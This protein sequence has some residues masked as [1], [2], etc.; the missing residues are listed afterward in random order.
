M[1]LTES[2]SH[3]VCVR[4]SVDRS[5]PKFN[6]LPTIW[7]VMAVLPIAQCTH[8]D[9]QSNPQEAPM[10]MRLILMLPSQ[11]LRALTKIHG[12]NSS[13]AYQHHQ[14]VMHIVMPYLRQDPHNISSPEALDLT[15]IDP[16]IENVSVSHTCIPDQ[17]C[18]LTVRSSRAKRHL[19]VSHLKP[20]RRIRTSRTRFGRRTRPRKIPRRTKRVKNEPASRQ[21]RFNIRQNLKYVYKGTGVVVMFGTLGALSLGIADYAGWLPEIEDSGHIDI[22]SSQLRE[23][24]VDNAKLSRNLFLMNLHNA[25]MQSDTLKVLGDIKDGLL[26][27]EDATAAI[28]YHL[29]T[30]RFEIERLLH[31]ITSDPPRP[32]H[33]SE[34]TTT[35]NQHMITGCGIDPSFIYNCLKFRLIGVVPQKLRLYVEADLTSCPVHRVNL[36]TAKRVTWVDVEQPDL[37]PISDLKWNDELVDLWNH[38]NFNLNDLANLNASVEQLVEKADQLPSRAVRIWLPSTLTCAV[39]IGALGLLLWCKRRGSRTSD[40]IRQTFVTKSD[41]ISTIEQSLRHPE[42]LKSE[43]LNELKMRYGEYQNSH[44]A[45]PHLEAAE[46]SGEE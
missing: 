20:W 24:A 36:T 41:S 34:M 35:L 4:M 17:F 16:Q 45:T 29:T 11:Y 23:V 10:L 14:D 27:D 39:M 15:E 46:G 42:G 37:P 3:R 6:I 8:I 33:L 25:N 13:L 44:Y 31:E 28:A 9:S 1:L 30:E 26:E 32:Y 22:L 2:Y 18:D 21:D 38:S 19:S 40:H 5:K 7:I 12:D 43:F